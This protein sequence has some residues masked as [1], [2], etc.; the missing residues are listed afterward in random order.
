MRINAHLTGEMLLYVYFWALLLFNDS[1]V[2][3]TQ[4]AFSSIIPHVVMHTSLRYCQCFQ[5][6]EVHL[7]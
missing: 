4:N 3:A 6:Y 2:Y 1:Q 5:S 7:K